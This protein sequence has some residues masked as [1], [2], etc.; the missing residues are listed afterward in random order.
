[1]TLILR[2]RT[3]L[4][5]LY[6]LFFRHDISCKVSDNFIIVL[7]FFLLNLRNLSLNFNMDL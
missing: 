7:T 1:M 6:V 2:N 3:G 5:A 4:N